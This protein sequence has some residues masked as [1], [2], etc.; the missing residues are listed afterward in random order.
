M[1]D[2]PNGHIGITGAGYFYNGSA[3]VGTVVHWEIDNTNGSGSSVY[4][5]GAWPQFHHDPQL[6]R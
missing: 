4:E 1:T 5:K 6:T 3:L 2:D